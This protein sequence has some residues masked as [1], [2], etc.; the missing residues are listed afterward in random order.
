METVVSPMKPEEERKRRLTAALS[1]LDSLAQLAA[2]DRQ[3]LKKQLKERAADLRGLLLDAATPKVRQ[4]L[5]K[6]LVGKVMMQPVTVDGRGAYKLSATL[7]F[8]RLLPAEIAE[9]VEPSNCGGP[10]GRVEDWRGT[11]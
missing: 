8:G 10:D 3:K 1:R 9:L 4:A 2:V 6:I 7:S 5:R 11:P